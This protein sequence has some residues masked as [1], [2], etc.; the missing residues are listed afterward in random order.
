[1]PVIRN[2]CLCL[3]IRLCAACTNLMHVLVYACMSYIWPRWRCL[4]SHTYIIS[5]AIGYETD[6]KCYHLIFRCVNFYMKVILCTHA[7]KADNSHIIYCRTM[8]I[9][10]LLLTINLFSNVVESVN[11]A[12]RP[13]PAPKPVPRQCSS[14]SDGSITT[15]SST[16]VSPTNGDSTNVDTSSPLPP[17]EQEKPKRAPPSRPPPPAPSRPAPPA[18]SAKPATA[19]P[20]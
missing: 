20:G 13:K 8:E 1:M 3:C 10:K 12:P 9:S 19:T 14:V 18:P 5:D 4:D 11:A 6:G 17:S 15:P 2:T 16:P 7:H